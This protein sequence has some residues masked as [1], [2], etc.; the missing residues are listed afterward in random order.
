V[1]T[2]EQRF[3]VVKHLKNGKSS[4]EIVQIMGGQIYK[5][6]IRGGNSGRL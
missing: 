1:L 3:E 4:R 6:L 2:L 5:L